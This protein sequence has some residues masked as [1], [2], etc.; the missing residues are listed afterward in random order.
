MK[1]DD[2]RRHSMT[3]VLRSA[4]LDSRQITGVAAGKGWKACEVEPF[5]VQRWPL[6]PL[7]FVIE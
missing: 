4:A 7:N 5:F 3:A 2:V 1:A 6:Y